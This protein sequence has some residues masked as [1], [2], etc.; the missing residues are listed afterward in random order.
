MLVARSRKAL[1]EPLAVDA[2]GGTSCMGLSSKPKRSCACAAPARARAADAAVKVASFLM[3][4][5]FLRDFEK[6]APR[7][8][9]LPGV[10]P[11]GKA[12]RGTGIPQGA[13]RETR[14]ALSPS[15]PPVYVFSK[16]G[17]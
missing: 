14:R 1:P 15:L 16:G 3:T 2:V 10:M 17:G 12:R 8:A 13:R 6:G 9:G 11:D 5:S 4:R 7:S